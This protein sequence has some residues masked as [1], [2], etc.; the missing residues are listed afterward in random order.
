[1]S[2]QTGTG[3]L[4]RRGPE[5]PSDRL[6]EGRG[7]R[8][9]ITRCSPWTRCYYARGTVLSR[10]INCNKTRTAC[11]PPR[12][13]LAISNPRSPTREHLLLLLPH[14]TQGVKRLFYV[15][16]QLVGVAEE[17]QS[18]CRVFFLPRRIAFPLVIFTHSHTC[19]MLFVSLLVVLLPS[20]ASPDCV[21]RSPY[22]NHNDCSVRPGYAREFC[23]KTCGNCTGPSS[24]FPF[25]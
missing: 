12:V 20:L 21:D 15:A 13:W 14:S 9:F 16:V 5:A 17:V 7:Q 3:Q 25:S 11:F 4:R 6:F 1:M 10:A 2:G 8:L 23:K 22:C 19:P 24:L 18:V